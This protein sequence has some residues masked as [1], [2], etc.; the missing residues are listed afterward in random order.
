MS[1]YV[2]KCLSR[3]PV[4]GGREVL[5]VEQQKVPAGAP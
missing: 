3:A 5:Y 1:E 4:V 2:V